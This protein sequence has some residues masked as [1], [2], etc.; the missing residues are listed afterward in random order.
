MQR[1]N[2]ERN[3]GHEEQES[4]EQGTRDF[5]RVAIRL[6]AYHVFGSRENV[7]CR[8]SGMMAKKTGGVNM[9]KG[10]MRWPDGQAESLR[11]W[12]NNLDRRLSTST[13]FADGSAGIFQRRSILGRF[14][15]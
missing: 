4:L 14:I 12:E 11:K 15:L 6:F 7:G 9:E 1:G 13:L 5:P 3:E 10:Q 8:N 2:A